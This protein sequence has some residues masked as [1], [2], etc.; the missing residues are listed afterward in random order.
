MMLPFP[1]TTRTLP[2]GS[3]LAVW[4]QAGPERP[5]DGEG[6]GPC[7]A[8]GIEDLS[9]R[10]SEVAASHD[11]HLARR[12]GARGVVS[13]CGDHV[14]RAGEAACACVSRG[15]EE[16]ALAWVVAPLRPPATSTFPEASNVAV[17][18]WRAVANEPV[19]T[20]A[21]APALPAA[22]KSSALA[23]APELPQLLQPPTTS[24][25]PEESKV[26]V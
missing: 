14:S 20:N 11:E 12:Q 5:R 17:C 6:P 18:A 24:T 1:P 4:P 7:V 8:R 19:G 9:T 25:V 10:H 23:S 15:V 21:P 16:L 13:A 3:T 22:S 26:A 2:D